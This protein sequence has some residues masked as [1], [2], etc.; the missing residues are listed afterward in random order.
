MED[1]GWYTEKLSRAMQNDA[2]A[3]EELAGSKYGGM[4]GMQQ[5]H[6]G[7][8]DK[9]LKDQILLEQERDQLIQDVLQ[10]YQAII[11]TLESKKKDGYTEPKTEIIA[12]ALLK[13]ARATQALL[14]AYLYSVSGQD[15]KFRE[16]AK[17][18]ISQGGESA[19]QM[20][21]LESALLQR[22]GDI[23]PALRAAKL[24]LQAKGETLRG[25]EE[26]DPDSKTKKWRATPAFRI[27]KK[28]SNCICST[29]FTDRSAVKQR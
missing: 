19:Y 26:Q 3:N 25:V 16:S 14:K 23:S 29:E 27:G 9:L 11:Q 4:E 24:A 10:D 17:A 7:A 5:N 20:R 2:R 12:E 28:S 15:D 21:L 13:Q 22:K 6:A 8:I 18:V 1:D